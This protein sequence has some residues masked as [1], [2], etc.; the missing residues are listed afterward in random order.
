MRKQGCYTAA[1][2]ERLP[3]HWDIWEET[4]RKPAD[5]AAEGTRRIDCGSATAEYQLAHLPDGRWAVR[6]KC[7]LEFVT[8][9]SIPWRA[10]ATRELCRAL[11]NS[12]VRKGR[13]RRL[14]P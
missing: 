10:F 1:V 6:M 11:H 7:N 9:T 2:S 5:Q 3:N 4:I 14:M 8:G 13:Q 12:R